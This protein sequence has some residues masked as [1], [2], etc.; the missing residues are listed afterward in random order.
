M[1]VILKVYDR[2]LCGCVECECVVVVYSSVIIYFIFDDEGVFEWIGLRCVG[3][4]GG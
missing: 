3:S 2:I 1:L 4:F